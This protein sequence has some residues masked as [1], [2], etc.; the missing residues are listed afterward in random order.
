MYFIEKYV[1]RLSMNS[2]GAWSLQYTSYLQNASSTWVEKGGECVGFDPPVA[3]DVK[4]G[5]CV[6]FDPLVLIHPFP[7]SAGF[8]PPFALDVK[9]G[10]WHGVWMQIMVSK[11]WESDMVLIYLSVVVTKHHRCCHQVQRG[12]L[13]EIWCRMLSLMATHW[14]KMKTCDSWHVLSL[15]AIHLMK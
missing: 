10:E 6:G 12:R 3:L 9:G 1:W 2:G 4:G 8:D 13:L 15:M 5:E 7:W 14:M 11:N